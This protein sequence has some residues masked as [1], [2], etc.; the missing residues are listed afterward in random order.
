MLALTAS[1]MSF[2]QISASDFSI[3]VAGNYTMY[4]GDFQKST[5][6]IKL[7]LGYGVQSKVGFTLGFTKGF[8][9]KTPSEINSSNGLGDSKTTSSQIQTNFSTVSLNVNYRFIGD[10]ET[11]LSVYAPVGASFVMAKFKETP[12]EAI[13][14]GYT[15]MDQMEPGKES[16]FT[17]NGGL[18]VMY[19]IGV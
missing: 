8:A 5:P 2:A 10:E 1:T 13:P 12:N 16:G 17:I 15:A 7:E 4:K 6:G 3:G 14:A 19:K 18:G 9:I 11:A